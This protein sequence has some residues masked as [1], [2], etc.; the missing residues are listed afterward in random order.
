MSNLCR[1]KNPGPPFDKIQLMLPVLAELLRH[2]DVQILSKF[3]ILFTVSIFD[4][5]LIFC[6]ILI[7]QPMHRGQ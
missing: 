4:F 5:V 3:S 1:N 7:A 2:H 6:W